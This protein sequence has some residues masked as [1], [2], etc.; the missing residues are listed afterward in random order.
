MQ[1]LKLRDFGS[2]VPADFGERIREEILGDCLTGCYLDMDGKARAIN[3]ADRT[4]TFVITDPSLDSYKEIVDAGA[5]DNSLDRYMRNPVM[6]PE[7]CHLFWGSSEPAS[8]GVCRKTF[9]RGKALLGTFEF[10]AEPNMVAVLRWSLYV[11]GMWRA[12]SVGFRPVTTERDKDG[13]LHYTEAQLKEVSTCAVPANE[14]CLVAADYVGRRLAALCRQIRD[15]GL[16]REML[17]AVRELQARMDVAGS[18]EQLTNNLR[19][20]IDGVVNEV[21]A[22]G[23]AT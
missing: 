5:F 6:L 16:V 23:A 15:D 13:I 22:I 4:A 11:R 1:I 9:K 3:E 2:L 18:E 20:R 19:R 21:A 12:V 8:V 14:N 7:H 10:D 17:S